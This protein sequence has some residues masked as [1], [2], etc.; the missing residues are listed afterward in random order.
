MTQP[1]PEGY[2]TLTPYL[3]LDDAAGAIDFYKRAFGARERSRME[4]PGGKIMHAELEI[5]DSMV[6]LADAWPESSTR[7]P[8]DLGGTSAGVF[9]FHED[10]DSLAQQARDAGATVLMEPEDMF[11]GDRFGTLQDPY[12]HVWHVATH[13]EDVEPDEMRRRAE[14]W[15]AQMAGAAQS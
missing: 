2:S 9:V 1:I 11:W 5:G 12:G 15:Q 6:M 4:G 10:V 8:R 14:E 13:V 3:A 7:A